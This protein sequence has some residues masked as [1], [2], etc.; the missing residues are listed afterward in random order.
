MQKIEEMTKYGRVSRKNKIKIGVLL[1]DDIHH[2]YHAAPIG[3]ALSQ[4][5][6]NEVE[7]YFNRDCNKD[8]ALR[9]ASQFPGQKAKF[10]RLD[11]PWRFRFYARLRGRPFP[12]MRRVFK[13]HHEQLLRNDTLLLADFT[14]VSELMKH[15]KNSAT[16]LVMC[17]H[18]AGDR[19][20][21]FSEDLKFFDLLLVSGKKYKSR[22]QNELNISEKKVQII[23]YPKFDIALKNAARPVF[24]DQNPVV[25]YNPHFD[26]KL[27]SWFNWGEQILHWFS[28]NTQYNLILA[29][30][31][32]L[33]RKYN[34]E[35]L[36]KKFNAKN[37]YLAS[38]DDERCANMDFLKLAD[39][40][41]GDVSSQ[42]YEFIYRPRPCLFL[43]SHQISWRGSPN[44]YHWQLGPVADTLDELFRL[45]PQASK[46]QKDFEENQKRMFEETFISPDSLASAKAAELISEL[47]H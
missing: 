20:Y 35:K 19:A 28:K 24:S 10:R 25:I 30:H 29:P 17:F 42:V 21:A 3:F 12:K 32:M 9:L 37:I 27:A 22:I 39:L 14:Q 34:L 36:V 7:F 41:M 11:L 23:G 46:F 45:I 44:Y 31:I 16:K 13:Q 5:E 33:T 38:P 43:N 8:A 40:Y 26:E 2:V 18:G 1:L 47:H 15:K 6:E 4:L